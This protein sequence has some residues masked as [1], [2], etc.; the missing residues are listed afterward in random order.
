MYDAVRVNIEGYLELRDTAER[1]RDAVELRLAE[2]IVML[3][4]ESSPSYTWIR[5]VCS[6]SAAV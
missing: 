6:F 5:T 3:R 1:A 2:E 4:G